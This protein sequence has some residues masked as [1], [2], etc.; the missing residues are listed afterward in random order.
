MNERTR[1]VALLA[2]V[3]AV[4]VAVYA[5]GL[6]RYLSLDQLALHYDTLRAWAE[7]HPVLAPLMF[8]AV[9]A[10]AIAVSVPGALV[11]T[12]TAGFLFGTWIG[13]LVAVIAA[14]LGATAI[15]LIARTSLGEPLRR[16]ATGAGFQR[17]QEGFQADALSYLMVLR[18][19]P[20]FPFWLVNLVPAFLGVPLRTFVLAT[21]VGMLP[22]T[23]VY[24]SLGNGVGVLL[25][26][27]EEPD[28]GI[29]FRPAIFGP[30]LGLAALALLPVLYKRWKARTAASLPSS[31]PER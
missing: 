17:M 23:L 1:S 22:G 15:F 7:R 21:A 14:T 11:L 30:L 28:L 19:L 8:G 10:A 5:S 25:A 2:A 24:A 27:G 13:G 12:L 3:A 9:Y 20:L 4:L 6:H 18:L 29:I 26:M 31:E 16:R